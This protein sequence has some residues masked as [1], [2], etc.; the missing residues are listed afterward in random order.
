M[1]A[2]S[3]MFS[4]FVLVF[5]AEAK[6][7]GVVGETFPVAETSFLTLIETRLS[8]LSANGEL[9]T[10]NQQWVNTVANHADR[11]SPLRLSRTLRSKSHYYVPEVVLSHAITDSSG[12][13]LYPVGTQV[14]ALQKLPSYS[15][16]WMFFNGDDEAQLRWALKN[17][18]GCTNPKMIL[19]GGA[20]SQAEQKLNAVIYFDQAGRISQKLEIASVPAIVRREGD[21][22][23]IDEQAIKEN[24][25]V[26]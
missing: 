1:K 11:P 8:M 13:V 3:L 12:R 26:Q 9:N 22:L 15:P 4:M 14:N 17:K 18:S 25:D 21:Q 5:N 20:V 23:R 24:G 7:F 16:C 2:I 6:S 10:L 19:T